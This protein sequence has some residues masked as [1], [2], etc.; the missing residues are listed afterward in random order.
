MEYI[1]V[2]IPH[3]VIVLFI[4]VVLTTQNRGYIAA[5]VAT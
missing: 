5:R 2:D 3:F 4:F 1:H